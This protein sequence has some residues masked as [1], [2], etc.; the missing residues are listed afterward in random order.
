M[1]VSVRSFLTAGMAAVTASALTIAPI[2]VMA[3][4]PV[5]ATSLRLTAAVQPLVQP[6]T[7]AAAAVLGVVDAPAPAKPAAA[8]TG[9]V[10]P[11]AAATASATSAGS[12]IINAYNAI[13]P[14]VAYGFELGQ[15]VLG[16]IPGLWW[17]APGVSLAY[18]TIEPVVQSLVYS[19]AYLI[20]G[21]LAAIGPTLAAGL[22]QAAVN[23]INYGIAW[24]GSLVPLPPFP[25]LPPL[26]GAASRSTL[27]ATTAA[28]ADVPSVR[29]KIANR[30]AP[31]A[32]AA[33]VAI[34]TPV[35]AQNAGGDT[36]SPG[37][38]S[39][40]DV[41]APAVA[42]NTTSGTDTT[43]TDGSGADTTTPST[44]NPGDDA[45]ASG[46]TPAATRDAGKP[47]S[48]RTAHRSAGKTPS[49]ANS[50]RTAKARS[51]A[52]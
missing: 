27:A 47:D 42:E 2:Q 51:S 20:D 21:N 46:D 10:Q 39:T 37:Q 24:I 6:V 5:S 41:P 17:V 43:S 9:T 31:A 28:A 29:G 3:P 34:D 22:N 38:T 11:Q 26:P 23:F 32:K 8:G 52:R 44:P 1:T 19:F 30:V 13:E 40:P 49:A 45:T 7:T 25:P 12:V 35:D 16:F 14:W 18:Y 48:A 50:G 33:E 4:Q 15:Y 36:G